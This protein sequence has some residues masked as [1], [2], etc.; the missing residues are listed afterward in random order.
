M[1][2]QIYGT[3]YTKKGAFG[4]FEWMC[5]QN[6]YIDSLFIFNDNEE[7][8]ATNYPGMGN[9]VIRKYN[10]YNNE[11]SKPK[12]AGICTGTLKH[13]GYKELSKHN[14]NIIDTNIAEIK[15]IIKQY[16]YEYIYYSV[17]I[18]NK[19][20]TSIFTVAEDVINYIDKQIS[21]LSTLDVI[22]R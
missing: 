14:K 6:K 11:L 3:H 7:Y 5:T 19:L 4:D 9:A 22:Y 13:K 15:N 16:K 10:K 17:G 1:N 12:S 20:G 18:N 2:I 21:E 8:H